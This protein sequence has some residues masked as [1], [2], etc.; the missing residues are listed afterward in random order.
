MQ[1]ALVHTCICV[2]G[3][4]L[5]VLAPLLTCWMGTADNQMLRVADV[6]TGVQIKDMQLCISCNSNTMST[7]NCNCKSEMMIK[8][9]KHVQHWR[10]NEPICTRMCNDDNM[11]CNICFN[12]Q[13]STQCFNS[14]TSQSLSSIQANTQAIS[15][16]ATGISLYALEWW[17]TA[18]MITLYLN[19][20]SQYTYDASIQRVL[21]SL[22]FASALIF[23]MIPLGT[24]SAILDNAHIILV[25]TWTICGICWCI[26]VVVQ[27]HH[28]W[29]YLHNAVFIRL[30]TCSIL[31]ILIVLQW[32]SISWKYRMFESMMLA[33]VVYSAVPLVYMFRTNQETT[34][35][36]T[37]ITSKLSG[38]P[39]CRLNGSLIL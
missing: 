39:H 31:S 29:S 28:E 3:G 24:E 30:A 19:K 6:T 8:R 5:A 4:T 9:K 38:N 14:D 1:T 22:E 20:H 35:C 37:K 10:A 7:Q 33:F 13:S 27:C 25:I 15:V 12:Y 23:A 16:F 11:Q 26:A 18:M 17:Q 34:S 36:N 2:I 21:A 32:C